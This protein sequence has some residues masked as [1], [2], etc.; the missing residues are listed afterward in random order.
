MYVGGV[1]IQLDE[2]HGEVHDRDLECSGKS[3]GVVV[4]NGLEVHRFVDPQC[5]VQGSIGTRHLFNPVP[6]PHEQNVGV[7]GTNIAGHMDGGFEDQVLVDQFINLEATFRLHAEFLES[8]QDP[9][10]GILRRISNGRI[11]QTHNEVLRRFLHPTLIGQPAKGEVQKVAIGDM[12][13]GHS[14]HQLDTLVRLARQLAQHKVFFQIGK[15]PV[16][17]DAGVPAPDTNLTLR[18]K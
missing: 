17:V 6:C 3:V 18:A 7:F 14:K 1:H 5:S 2:E 8:D 10:K 4:E 16:E 13:D 9:E 15:L 11:Q 12:G